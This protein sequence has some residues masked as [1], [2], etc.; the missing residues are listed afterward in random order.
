MMNRPAYY[1]SLLVY[2]AIKMNR[3]VSLKFSFI[4][5]FPSTEKGRRS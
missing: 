5:T 2:R 3:A 1:G 4:S